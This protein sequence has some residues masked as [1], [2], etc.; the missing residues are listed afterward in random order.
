MKIY[1]R[2]KEGWSDHGLENKSKTHCDICGE[3][4][5]ANP[6][7]GIYCNGNWKGCEYPKEYM[8]ALA[9]LHST[10]QYN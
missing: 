5:W 4:L 7:G 9:E 10:K 3:K 1:R 6:S 8:E 2:L